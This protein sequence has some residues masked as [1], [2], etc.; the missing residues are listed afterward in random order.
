MATRH[1][2]KKMRNDKCHYSNSLR[3]VGC[4]E[5]STHINPKVDNSTGKQD[6]NYK[7][8]LVCRLE[9]NWMSYVPSTAVVGNQDHLQRPGHKYDTIDIYTTS[10]I[11]L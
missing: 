7:Q 9:A 4:S 3:N 11:Y 5:S 1:R 2:T 8:N 10:E 6:C